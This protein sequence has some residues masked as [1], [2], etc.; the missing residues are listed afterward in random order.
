M[1]ECKTCIIG[2]DI[3]RIMVFYGYFNR[4]TSLGLIADAVSE[5][6]LSEVSKTLSYINF[7]VRLNLTAIYAN[8]LRSV[9]RN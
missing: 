2:R 7:S 3:Y 1:F 5:V 9:F 8:I 4:D 6:C